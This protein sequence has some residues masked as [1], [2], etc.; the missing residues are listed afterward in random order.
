MHIPDIDFKT[1]ES[2]RM[3]RLRQRLISGI[4]AL[5]IF[6]SSMFPAVTVF[7][8]EYTQPAVT[9]APESVTDSVQTGTGVP[10]SDEVFYLPADAGISG[11]ETPAETGEIA[12]D[13]TDAFSCKNGNVDISVSVRDGVYTVADGTEIPV[14]NVAFTAYEV[15]IDDQGYPIDLDR[16]VNVVR[17]Y[18]T[19]WTWE[20]VRIVPASGTARFT[21][22]FTEDVPAEYADSVTVYGVQ[23]GEW[24]AVDMEYPVVEGG[25]VKSVSFETAL[26]DLSMFA[27]SWTDPAAVKPDEAI[28]SS[29]REYD[30]AD[31][32]ITACAT[33]FTGAI[34]TAD[35]E[36]EYGAV[37]VNANTA[38]LSVD[39]LAA[40][41]ERTVPFVVSGDETVRVYAPKF[42]SEKYTDVSVSDYSVQVTYALDT[43][44]PEAMGYSCMAFEADDDGISMIPSEKVIENG[45]I[46]A[47]TFTAN[48]VFAVYENIEL[49]SLTASAEDE[50]TITL[51]YDKGAGIPDGAELIAVPMD[52]DDFIADM[53][54]ALGWTDEDMVL[55]TR[56]FDITIEKD[57]EE[58]EPLTPVTVTAQLQD[59]EEVP[60]AMQVVHIDD[61]GAT[62]VEIGASEGEQYTFET[63][64]F[65]VYGFGSALHTVI[66]E[67]TDIADISVYTLSA[68]VDVTAQDTQLDTPV[69]G[70]IIDRAYSLAGDSTAK[71]WIKAEV[72]ENA[73]LGDRESVSLYGVDNGIVTRPI[74][75]DIAQQ[76]GLLAA[77]SGV[78]AIAVA[79]D[80]GLRRQTA[81]ARPDGEESGKIVSLSGMMPINAQASAADV[82]GTYMQAYEQYGLDEKPLAAYDIS[83]LENT[84]AEDGTASSVKYQP[85]EDSPVS[86]EITDPRID[87]EDIRIYHITGDGMS[88][89]ITEFEASDG[90]LRFAA[91][92]FSVYEVV[93]NENINPL[94]GNYGWQIAKS[95]QDIVDYGENG[96][97]ISNHQ[98]KYYLT[99]G[100]VAN[101]TDDRTGIE[102]TT[103]TTSYDSPPD[104]ACKFY[105]E[106]GDSDDQF[107]IFKIEQSEDSMDNVS[108]YIQMTVSTGSNPMRGGLKF[109]DSKSE[110]TP[111]TL[112]LNK[113]SF[114]CSYVL[115]ENESAH[116]W[117]RNTKAQGNGAIVSY[118]LKSDPN[119]YKLQLH[120]KNMIPN[121]PYGLDGETYGLMYYTVGN[122]GNALMAQQNNRKLVRISVPQDSGESRILY[123][124]PN[125]DISMW[126]FSNVSED[127]YK[128][129][130]DYNGVT[131][132]VKITSDGS[133]EFT[134]EE[135]EAS[136]LKVTPGTASGSDGTYV[137][138]SGKIRLS[139]G[140]YSIYYDETELCF[141]TTS[142]TDYTSDKYWLSF[143]TESVLD[144]D[145]RFVYSAEKVDLSDKV[146]VPSGTPDDPTKVVV[147]TRIWDKD[148]LKYNYYAIDCDGTL[149][150]CYE[151]GNSIFWLGDQIN[152]FEWDF[153]A[154]YYD[155]GVTEN[156]YYKLYN[157][158]SELYILP[159]LKDDQT[160]TADK[161][162]EENGMILDGRKNGDAY[163]T[164]YAWDNY[165]K[166]N[167]ALTVDEENGVLSVANMVECTPMTIYFAKISEMNTDETEP[168]EIVETVDNDDYGIKMTM[169]NYPGRDQNSGYATKY[170]IKNGSNGSKAEPVTGILSTNLGENG[171]PTINDNHNVNS[172]NVDFST[173]FT[174]LDKDGNPVDLDKNSV[175]DISPAAANHLFIK[176]THDE[177]GYF[178]YN[179]CENFAS[180]LDGNGR[181]FTVY[182]QLGTAYYESKNSLKHGQFLPYNTINSG[183]YSANNPQN[184]YTYS[185]E[186]L[187]DSDPRK[188][189]NLYAVK[190]ADG[191]LMPDYFLG[192]ELSA[193]FVQTPE[194][195]DAWGH[196][197]IFEFTG[198]DDFW[199]YVDGELVLDLGGTHAAVHGDVNFRTGVV[200]NNNTTTSLRDIYYRNLTGRG[201]S[202]AEA[203]EKCSEI[204]VKKA[205]DG[206]ERWVF[207]NYTS[208]TMKIFYMERGAGA[209][210]LY[211]RFNLSNVKPGTVTLAKNVT[212]TDADFSNVRFPYQIWY[213]VPDGETSDDD[214]GANNSR[215]V[216]YRRVDPDD[217][218]VSV[219]YV[220]SNAD[221][222]YMGEWTPVRGNYTYKDVFFVYP[223]K[224]I[225][226][227]FPD[228]IIDYVIR[229]CGV[230]TEVYD[231]VFVNGEEIDGVKWEGGNPNRM[232]YQTDPKTVEQRPAVEFTNNVQHLR[233]LRI[234]KRLVD[235]EGNDITASYPDGTTFK[236]RL[237]LG[238]EATAFDD[239][240]YADT[241]QYRL[242]NKDREYVYWDADRQQYVSTGEKV[243]EQLSPELQTATLT[244][245]SPNGTI[246]DVP[247]G[248]TVEIHDLLVGTKFKVLEN[249]WENPPGYSLDK[250]EM[251]GDVEEQYYRHSVDTGA[252][253]EYYDNIGSIIDDTTQEPVMYVK[254]KLGYGIEVNKNWTDTD[255]DAEHDPIYVAL[256]KKNGELADRADCI[257][258]IGGDYS[259]AYYYF[260]RREPIDNGEYYTR[261][262]KIS[263]D[264]TVTADTVLRIG[265]VTL[266]DWAEVTPVE[267]G[268]RVFNKTDQEYTVSYHESDMLTSEEFDAYLATGAADDKPLHS[269]IDTITNTRKGGIAI[270]LYKWNST[271]VLDEGVFTITKSVNGGEVESVGSCTYT[272][273][274]KVDEGN[275]LVMYGIEPNTVYTVTQKKTKFGWTGALRGEET[276]FSFSTGNDGNLIADADGNVIF[277]NSDGSPWTETEW[278]SGVK[279]TGD[280]PALLGYINVYNKPYSLKVLKHKTG[281]DIPVPGVSFEVYKEIT[282][283]YGL[284]SRPNTVPYSGFERDKLITDVNGEIDICSFGILPAGV[285]YLKEIDTPTGYVGLTDYIKF[286]VTPLGKLTVESTEGA[287]LVESETADKTEY[288][289]VI[290]VPNEENILAE[291]TIT[292]TVEGSLGSRTKEFT[293]TLTVEGAAADDTYE[294]TR[295]GEVQAEPLKSGGTFTLR[296]DDTVTLSLPMNT[297]ITVTEDAQGYRKEYVLTGAFTLPDEE[298]KTTFT[299]QGDALLA[300]TNS[301]NGAV[302]T[303]ADLPD[304]SVFFA[305]F[306]ALG[307]VLLARRQKLFAENDTDGSD[308]GK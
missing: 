297:A 195:V 54:E 233:S 66:E 88:E 295:N 221:V 199:L 60:E 123:V 34:F 300:V 37:P 4:T 23:F 41:D 205:V 26:P 141:K 230:S 237:Y 250:Y 74:L 235:E 270:S 13:G 72:S 217:P 186:E 232:F 241:K 137:N 71:L 194:G 225:S 269:R 130:A 267:E 291:L 19:A 182:R 144:E 129:S 252:G 262:V 15:N 208:H 117:N 128:L 25:L 134:S 161:S 188:Y 240:Q 98:G 212:G 169:V 234:V 95:L 18:N 111:F 167:A 29:D 272:S 273:T 307:A 153:T 185:L 287:Q 105:F 223:N 102:A 254:N 3:K 222:E 81:E 50:Y 30:Y 56:L 216:H 32:N 6:A 288:K 192:M 69:E 278:V 115:R 91:A 248:Y 154:F 83:I 135:S 143:V 80:T 187:P 183:K 113:D 279:E 45:Y 112:E 257:Q 246:A 139:S 96:F 7:S 213:R 203:E 180:L 17:A 84:V 259:Q 89:E 124:E 298:D 179:S 210:N 268:G 292:K 261:E 166:K 9:G 175:K 132:W 276:S 16:R 78:T 271:D 131:L 152:T 119:V 289:Y 301:L 121:D 76:E 236:F 299:L 73:E 256:Y 1:I 20:S 255:F 146:Q 108:Y 59:V 263:G 62:E 114:Y 264:F 14:S 42:S 231:H 285:Y 150:P 306:L 251:S 215:L 2:D 70:V 219:S 31:G 35:E 260:E 158:S 275:V 100:D 61:E 46:K 127:R 53:A 116:Y 168:L 296:H 211:M 177:S 290:D 151:S 204:F 258:Q 8:E 242:K 51:K 303:G 173:L 202:A 138:H 97:Y 93:K 5:S 156:G 305:G 55:Y 44:V 10:T 109:V 40:D 99:G 293:F 201:M 64:S 48:D 77:P 157:P 94:E 22:N 67:S 28:V 63:E 294:W 125:S 172:Q 170:F 304:V 75:D 176:G 178:V 87:G 302:P 282:D 227:K 206:T 140:S 27:L 43:P 145:E 107:Y 85:G 229:E 163:S 142:D 49:K 181:D 174:G 36:N 197:V 101:V 239:L 118:Q 126:T 218:E 243:L 147:Y 136:E 110:G 103:E 11:E 33:A 189:E 214:I 193:G 65:S 39:E 224:P 120:Y 38:A 247:V 274:D 265:V 92:G 220:E 200:H 244:Q 253:I 57:G 171:Y 68:D 283:G 281:S 159:Q 79:R 133:L 104:N 149:H 58:F 155:D 280:D 122:V 190:D 24:T 52:A 184:L 249:R 209:S 308:N 207:K 266:S 164:V 286:S 148:S 90:M 21:Y 238:D 198:D 106:K 277:T 245:T 86:V 160:L 226:I 82:T 162:A 284:I 165:Y 12:S 228:N 47:I 191:N 196:D